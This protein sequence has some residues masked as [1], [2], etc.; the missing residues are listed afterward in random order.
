M[1]I[2]IYE[3]NNINPH[4]Y[5]QIY[6]TYYGSKRTIIYSKNKILQK[7]SEEENGASNYTS[8]KNR[9]FN[10]DLAI[11]EKIFE[12]QT[13]LKLRE[14]IEK[15]NF[16]VNTTLIIDFGSF[17]ENCEIKHDFNDFIFAYYNRNDKASNLI[18]QLK[19]KVLN[20]ESLN[21]DLARNTFNKNQEI[22]YNVASTILLDVFDNNADFLVVDN[23]EDF[24]IFDYNRKLLE[25]CCGR[26]VLIPIIHV[27]ELQ[28][29]ASGNHQEA[30]ATLNKHQIDPEII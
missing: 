12:L 14:D 29:L 18:S 4:R 2:P 26:D 20:L 30:K 16:R 6:F 7:L 22:T 24:Y 5:L 27:N 19:A 11:E 17:E 15:Q 21:L 10:F 3:E 28:K 1:G 23:D 8:L 9:I 13:S 25:K